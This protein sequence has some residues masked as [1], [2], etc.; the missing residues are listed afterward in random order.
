MDLVSLLTVKILEIAEIMMLKVE[1][2]IKVILRCTN[3]LEIKMHAVIILVQENSLKCLM[4]KISINLLCRKNNI[5]QQVDSQ[6][7]IVY[8]AT[9]IRTLS[10]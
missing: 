6:D 1:K 5:L 4:L 2:I 3:V 10:L 8:V 9:G 7:V